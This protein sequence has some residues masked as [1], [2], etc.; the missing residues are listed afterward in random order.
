[1]IKK[2]LMVVLAMVFLFGFISITEASPEYHFRFTTVSVPGDAHTVALYELKAQIEDLTDG[3]IQLGIYHSGALFGQEAGHAAV[4][5]GDPLM[6]YLSPAWLAD[7]APFLSMFAAGYMFKDYNHMSSFY[8]SEYGKEVFDRIAE[9]TGI[10]PLGAFYL[11]SRQLNYRDI[12]RE[13]R[14]PEDLR[15]VIL[16]MPDSPAWLFL[17]SALGASPT[18][19]SFPE[20]YMALQTGTV[21]GQDNPLPTVKHASFY[22]VT[23]YITLTDHL[24]DTVMPS[25]NEEIWQSMDPELQELMYQA[26]EAAR[27]VCDRLNLAAESELVAYFEEQGLTVVEADKEAFMN[28]VQNYYLSDESMVADWDMDLYERV[29]EMVD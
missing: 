16:R 9:E 5:R 15:G 6:A 21:D 25:I 20:L 3:R 14:T 19:V 29:Q 7:E 17:G 11:G 26:V 2:S 4:K 10:R 18:P 27:Q 8:Q 22:E 12:G 24:I 23:D 28:H 1:M 13:V